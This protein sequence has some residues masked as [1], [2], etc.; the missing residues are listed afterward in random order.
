MANARHFRTIFL[1]DVHLGSK[2]ARTDLLLDFLR[3]HE[4]D[5]IVLVASSTGGG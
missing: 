5:T 4:A 3:C 1:S 2:A